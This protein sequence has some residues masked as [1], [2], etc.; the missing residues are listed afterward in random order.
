MLKK[1]TPL[2]SPENIL[3]PIVPWSLI[4]EYYSTPGK[5]SND[6]FEEHIPCPHINNRHIY[7]VRVK[8]GNMARP[9]Y[10]GL[11][12]P[13]GT[14]LFVDPEIHH[15]HGNKVI[16]TYN[17]LNEPVCRQFII[18]GDAHY[19]MPFM[20]LYAKEF[21]KKVDGSVLFLGVIVG[22]YWSELDNKGNLIK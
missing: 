5:F 3:V 21:P 4:E 1:Y 19:L 15:E 7:A 6:D 10:G 17:R 14:I 2:Y 8:N 20:P 11:N 13:E 16:A 18:D 9:M 12:Y 22:A